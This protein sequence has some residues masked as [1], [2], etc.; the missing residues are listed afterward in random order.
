M[1]YRIKQ[2]ILKWTDENIKYKKSVDNLINILK[3]LKIMFAKC[4]IG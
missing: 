3:G 2:L 1:V 4:Y